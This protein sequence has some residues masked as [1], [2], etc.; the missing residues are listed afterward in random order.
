MK[1]QENNIY[2]N[3]EG[4][5]FKAAM[6]GDFYIVDCWQCDKNGIVQDIEINPYPTPTNT[7]DFKPVGKADILN[8]Y[9]DPSK[10]FESWQ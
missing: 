10:I 1:I 3:S 4:D 7:S 9:P 8:N 5:F 2:Q 6:S